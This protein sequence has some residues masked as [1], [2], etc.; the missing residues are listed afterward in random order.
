M[1]NKLLWTVIIVAV[2]VVGWA[3]FFKKG[4]NLYGPSGTASPTASPG[5]FPGSGGSVLPGGTPVA[6]NPQNYSE[7]VKQYE[8]RR[9]EF[10]ERCQMRPNDVTFK[11]GTVVMFDNRSPQAKTVKVGN[12]NYSLPAYG[13]RFLTMSSQ[14]VPLS[15]QVGCDNVPNVGKILL[16]ASIL[17]Q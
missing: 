11:N 12:Q 17:Q 1:G 13:Y 10:D 6:L 7:L 15:L 16:Q 5:T 3:L 2:A 4:G 8:G 9:V 14:T